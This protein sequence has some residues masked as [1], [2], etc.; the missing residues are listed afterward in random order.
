MA[1]SPIAP[2]SSSTRSAIDAIYSG[3][4]QEDAA[5]PR[6]QAYI[7]RQFVRY[8]LTSVHH[9][10]GDLMALQEVRASGE[11][12]HRVSYE[13]HGTVLEAMI[14]NGIETG[15]GD[16]WMRFGATSEHT[17]T[18]RSPSAPWRSA[19]RIPESN[20]RYRGNLILPQDELNDWVERV[21]RAGIQLN[22][23][24]NGDVAID[25]VLTA[26][27]RRSSSFP[28][29]DLRP[30]ITHCTLINED[31]LRRIKATG[32]VPAPF[33]S[34][35]YYNPDKFHFYGARNDAALHGVSARS[36]EPGSR[37]PQAPIS[38]GAVCAVD[39]DPRDGHAHGL[40][41]RDLGREAARQRR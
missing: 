29:H 2:A 32:A 10:G 1:A 13:A 7:S 5:R 30:K 12:K 33:T 18:D 3:R 4:R 24:A 14:Q 19:S 11:L 21:H 6:R 38:A 41:R 28:R 37:R 27:E 40:E 22:C 23:H 31:L 8:G 34:Y 15:F 20:R 25:M 9:E 17:S 35:A 36:R 16:E 26:Y 39:G